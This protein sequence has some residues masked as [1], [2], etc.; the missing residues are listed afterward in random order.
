MEKVAI[1]GSGNAACAFSAYLGKKGHEVH[2]CDD[3]Q[4]IDNLKYMMQH[5]GL[6]MTG[7]EQGFGKISMITTDFEEA[8]DDVEIIMVVVPAFGHKPMAQK[9]APYLKDG[10]IVIL[11]PGAVFGAV[12]FLNTLRE[13]GNTADV[14]I[15]E[16]SSNMFATRRIGQDTVRINA[17]KK[18][19]PIATI[20]SNRVDLVVDKLKDFFDSYVTAPST[21]L[22]SL[23]YT[24]PVL[25]IPGILLNTGW[26]ERTGGNFNFYYDGISPSVAKVGLGIDKE[27]CAASL[28]MGY[29]SMTLMEQLID[30]YGSTDTTDIYAYYH[31]SK[32]HSGN[33]E[34]KDAPADLISTRYISEDVPYGLVPIS[35][36]AKV[37]DVPTFHMDAFITL[38]STVN[39][40]NYREEGRNLKSL[41]LDLKSKEE[42]IRFI[43]YGE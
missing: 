22:T 13:F 37:F 9:L 16:T 35:E 10:Q 19:L 33:K 36:I 6:N 20:P 43:N 18:K 42:I 28:A 21:I 17:V 3:E 27:R 41:G 7:A 30:W 14:T 39:D 15:A 11:N 23:L 40:T 34:E 26:I 24:N 29:P 4:F 31:H 12:E 32:V 25:H 2:L 1:L 38:S 8:I 5:N